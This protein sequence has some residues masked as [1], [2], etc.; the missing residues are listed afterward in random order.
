MY[1][2]GMGR[3]TYCLAPQQ[4]FDVVKYGLFAQIFIS[5]SLGATKISVC[6]FMLRVVDTAQKR[7]SRFLWVLIAFVTATHFVQI[8]LFLVQC[9]PLKA[10]WD[11]F[12]KG[13]CF[14]LHI[15]Y[16]IAYTNFGEFFRNNYWRH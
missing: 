11:P 16:M 2:S 3:H 14:S 1:V 5:M 6:V 9:R 8:V 12:Q 10:V 7:I 4:I 15:V 13:H